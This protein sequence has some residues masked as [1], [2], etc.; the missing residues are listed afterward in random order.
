MLAHIV[1]ASSPLHD[2]P[3]PYLN[4]LTIVFEKFGVDFSREE[5]YR[6]SIQFMDESVFPN[7]NIFK[8]SNGKWTTNETMTPVER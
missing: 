7:L 4:W 2:T 3:L 1:H 8:L 5:K 6:K